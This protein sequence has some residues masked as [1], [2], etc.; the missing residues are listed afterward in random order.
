VAVYYADLYIYIRISELYRDNANAH[1]KF[2]ISFYKENKEIEN[3]ACQL[4]YVILQVQN[5]LSNRIGKWGGNILRC[6]IIV[7]QFFRGKLL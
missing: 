2:T 1:R 3:S 5:H 4:N 6:I 7:A